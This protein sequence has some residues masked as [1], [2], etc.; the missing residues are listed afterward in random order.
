MVELFS[1]GEGGKKKN[2]CQTTPLPNLLAHPVEIWFG[3]GFKTSS[4]QRTKGMST[5]KCLLK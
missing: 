3:T 2:P 4:V 1:F 5:G